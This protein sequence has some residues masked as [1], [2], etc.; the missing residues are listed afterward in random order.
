MDIDTNAIRILV[1][2]DDPVLLAVLEELFHQLGQMNV[3]SVDSSVEALRI[4]ADVSPQPHLVICDLNM[5]DIDGIELLRQLK[6]Q[7]FQGH[8]AITTG[9][10]ERVLQTAMNLLRI[11]GLRSAG[12]VR[13]PVRRES[14]ESILRAVARARTEPTRRP[15]ARAYGAD[16]LRVALA[17]DQFYTVYQPQV[18]MDDLRVIGVEALVR[19]A[20]PQDGTV[21]PDQFIPV[22]EEFG[23]IDDLTWAVARSALTD[24][25]RFTEIGLGFRMS[26]NVSMDN[27]IDL[28]FPD[29]L[30]ALAT[31]VGASLGS[32]AIEITESRLIH[33]AAA[34]LDILARLRLKHVRLSIDDFGT[35]HSS[36][37]QLRDIPFDELKIDKG[38][39]QGAADSPT[40]RAIVEASLGMAHRLDVETVAE[41]VETKEDWEYLRAS[42]CDVVQGYFVGKPM[43]ADELESFVSSWHARSKALWGH[44]S[45]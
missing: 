10:D 26:I 11:Q 36:L 33:D 42:H 16:E 41:G 31:E 13:K 15:E 43:P 45:A 44:V 39:V 9:E 1:V 22:V 7:R 29:R 19:W 6:T 3:Q 2:D 28:A 30:V 4:L 24:L 12:C 8:V 21:Y 17:K 18:R 5:P 38:F 20:H 14:L 32:V 23:L 25:R 37:A 40:N 34:T 27:L 35:G